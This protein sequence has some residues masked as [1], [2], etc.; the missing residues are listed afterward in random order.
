MKNTNPLLHKS[1]KDIKVRVLKRKRVSVDLNLDHP[2]KYQ[3]KGFPVAGVT[4]KWKLKK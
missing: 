1:K 2:E 4:V 3:D